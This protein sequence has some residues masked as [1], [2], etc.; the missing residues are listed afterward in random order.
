M[1]RVV[2]LLGKGGQGRA[3]RELGWDRK[4]IRKGTKELESGFD[5]IDNFSGR[6]RKRAEDHLT[7]LLQDIKDTVDPVS[8]ADPAFRTTR[9]YTPL[10]AEEVRNR[11]IQDKN[12]KDSE[13]PEVRT[14]QT[15]LNE[16]NYHRDKVKKSRPQKKSK[17]QMPYLIMSVK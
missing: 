13:L 14:V 8:Q 6:G 1:G 4:T 5:C 7:D 10:T 12:Y 3:E 15:K 2:K 17:R 9:L 11:L 16:L